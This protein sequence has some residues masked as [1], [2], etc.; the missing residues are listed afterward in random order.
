MTKVYLSISSYRGYCPGAFHYYGRFHVEGN[1]LASTDVKQMMD[2]E[3]ATA[4]NTLERLSSD[5]LRAY[6]VG[7][8]TSKFM[9]RNDLIVRAKVQAIAEFGQDVALFL[10]HPVYDD[11]DQ[12]RLL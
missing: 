9:S 5:S 2:S 3:M 7:D 4:L 1:G 11:E 6:G 12:E 8:W 10:G